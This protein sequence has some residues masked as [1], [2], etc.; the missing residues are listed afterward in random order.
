MGAQK[1]A[2]KVWQL[3]FTPNSRRIIFPIW[4]P[5]HCS[6]TGNRTGSEMAFRHHPEDKPHITKS[7]QRSWVPV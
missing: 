6:P 3:L 2:A 4:K 5:L 1:T 7:L